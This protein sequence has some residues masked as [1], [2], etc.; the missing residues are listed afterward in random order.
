MPQTLR[1][2]LRPVRFFS[3]NPLARTLYWEPIA[4]DISLAGDM[5]YTTGPYS[6][7]DN[8]PEKVPPRYGF[9]FSVW[10]KQDDG[11]WKVVVDF[12]ATTTQEAAQFFGAKFSAAGHD[13]LA[14]A[15]KH[16]DIDAARTTLLRND[17]AFRHPA[18]SQDLVRAFD[19]ILDSKARLLREGM[20]PIVGKDSIL[21]YEAG[22]AYGMYLDPQGVDVSKSGDFGYTYGAYR[23]DQNATTASGYYLRVWKVNSKGLWKLVS[24]TEAPQNEGR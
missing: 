4:G 20:L 7:S 22:H 16:V 15:Q 8:G 14:N 5:G 10:K 9:F 23:T 12:G 13:G 17:R 3:A 19:G 21:A 1:R 11:C 6:L 2:S 24:E 18:A